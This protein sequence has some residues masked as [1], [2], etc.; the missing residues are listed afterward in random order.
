MNIKTL[1][2]NYKELNTIERNSLFISALIRKDKSEENAITSAS[3]KTLWEIPDF[4]H[5]YGKVLSLQ[6][7]VIIE[8]ANAWTNWQTFCEFEGERTDE[9]SRLALYFFFVYSDA[10]TAVCEYLKIDADALE[11]MLFPDS[12]LVMR[13]AFIDDAFRELAFTEKEAKEFIGQYAATEGT[14]N[15]TLENKIK[16]FK[17]FLEL[18]EK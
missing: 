15:M 6:M 4:T 8:K 11:K 17:D 5:L 2:K 1:R 3:P 18:P 7:I 16:E 13:L 9:H 12:F 14:L 10:W